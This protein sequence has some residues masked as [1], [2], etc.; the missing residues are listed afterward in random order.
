MT[1]GT[2]LSIGNFDGA[3]A[4]HVAL[5]RAAR[6]AVGPAGRVVALSFDPHPAAVLH[7]D[8]RPERLS[9]FSQ[10]A[11]WLE[12]AGA[13]QVVA[14][15]P[16]PRLLAQGPRE[17][18]ADIMAAHRP[19]VIVEGPDFRFGRDRQGSVQTLLELAPDLGY[20][21]IIVDAVE[22]SLTDGS[23]VVISSST[24]RWLL[25]Q[26]RVRDAARLLDR[27]YELIGQVVPGDR[28][29]RRIGMPT[30]NLDHG[31]C[32]LP[33]DGVYAGTARRPDG[34]VFPAAISVGTK[35]TFGH[36]P[37]VCEAHLIGFDGA[38]DEYGWTMTLHLVDWLR[39]QI[40]CPD[41]E[42]LVEQMRRDVDEARTICTA[43][44]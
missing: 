1:T 7:P 28:R 34:A 11:R 39:D 42:S 5:V 35:P 20:Q 4:G 2:A 38:M 21:A 23:V 18:L 40:T 32:L 13:D 30:A 36:H 26:G 16:T 8:R 19:S 24:I 33:A 6:D 37:R 27:P 43:V 3:H 22:A 41:R 31:G 15:S 9:L 10:R 12:T 14:L 25:R 17:F 29:G 44:S